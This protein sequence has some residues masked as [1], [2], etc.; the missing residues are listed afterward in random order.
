MAKKIQINPSTV[1]QSETS[2]IET[3]KKKELRI[4]LMVVISCIDFLIGHAPICM[5]FILSNAGLTGN[6]TIDNLLYE[7]AVVLV[8]LSYT[9]LFFEYFIINK[10]FRAIV[11]NV[12]LNV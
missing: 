6:D 11:K 10:R 12:Y 7:L 5:F 9:V 1:V 3:V 8:Y 4:T 2:Y